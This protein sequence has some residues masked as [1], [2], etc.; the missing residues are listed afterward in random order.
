MKL[1]ILAVLAI[2]AL[3]TLASAQTYTFGFMDGNGNLYCDYEQLWVAGGGGVYGIDN[4]SLCGS[5]QNPTLVGLLSSNP[6]LGPL[7]VT[8]GADLA[9]N[10]LDLGAGYVTGGQAFFHTAL[11]CNKLDKNGHPKGKY[12]W[13]ILVAYDGFLAG[14]NEGYLSCSIPSPGDRNVLNQTAIGTA[15]QN[16]KK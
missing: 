14:V 16:L 15:M 1:R 11:K 7:F 3:G 4:Q 8:S 9:T 12:G 2:L 13:V 5:S 10:A 6:Q